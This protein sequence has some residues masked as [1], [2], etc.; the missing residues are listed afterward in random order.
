MGQIDFI[1]QNSEKK[2]LCTFL[3]QGG[4]GGGGGGKWGGGG[5]GSI[6][7]C[8]IFGFSVGL[9]R[10]IGPSTGCLITNSKNSLQ[11]CCLWFSSLRARVCWSLAMGSDS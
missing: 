1:I 10:E 5:E 2:N 3:I 8:R 11:G 7:G 6:L 9:T 4:R